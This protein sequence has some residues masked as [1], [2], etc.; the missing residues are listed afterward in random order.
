MRPLYGGEGAFLPG[1]EAKFEFALKT[2]DGKEPP[3]RHILFVKVIGPG[4]RVLRHYCRSVEAP[5]GRGLFRFR[6][7]RNDPPGEW[8]LEV[9]DAATGV[10]GSVKFSVKPRG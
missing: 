9:R 5:S 10:K 4:G 2:E 6:L 1:G 7:A 8:G 3:G